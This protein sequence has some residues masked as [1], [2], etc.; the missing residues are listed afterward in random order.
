V[1]VTVENRG[2]RAGRANCEI[3]VVAVNG[4][5]RAGHRFS[6]PRVKG[7]ATVSAPVTFDIDADERISGKVTC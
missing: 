1:T 7:H 6:S 3:A 4:G 5:N 2:S